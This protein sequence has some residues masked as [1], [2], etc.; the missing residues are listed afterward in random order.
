MSIDE[1]DYMRADAP[2]PAP[3]LGDRVV[4]PPAPGMPSEVGDRVRAAT[5]DGVGRIAGQVAEAAASMPLLLFNPVAS[6][7]RIALS[8]SNARQ[9]WQAVLINAIGWF[10]VMAIIVV[11]LPGELGVL[12]R[13][14]I[15]GKSMVARLIPFAALTIATTVVRRVAAPPTQHAF[16]YDALGSASALLP[17]QAAALV[18][19]IAGENSF[20]R[21]L[22]V[23]SL[24]LSTLIL[25]GVAVQNTNGTGTGRVL[26]LI[27]LQVT[28]AF[29]I[30][31]EMAAKFEPELPTWPFPWMN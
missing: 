30:A 10:V 28:A 4:P 23:C 24:L 8:I 6:V 14:E 9:V 7:D 25:H 26:F 27:P 3:V 20:T 22:M 11:R 5:A 17:I 29:L 18:V 16:G 31:I 19:V 1:R 13:L 21:W 2:P 15:L 12:L